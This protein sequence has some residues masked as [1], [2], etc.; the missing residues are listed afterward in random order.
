[1]LRRA[2]GLSLSLI[3]QL[4]SED[5]KQHFII[6]PKVIEVRLYAN[7]S[8]VD[9]AIPLLQSLLT[10]FNPEAIL[11]H[12]EWAKENF[13]YNESMSCYLGTGA[14]DITQYHHVDSLC[15]EYRL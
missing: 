12:G 3:C 11:S 7:T 8:V 1:M 10:I 2:T 9:G 14:P 4:T 6:T 5:I 15:K 13:G